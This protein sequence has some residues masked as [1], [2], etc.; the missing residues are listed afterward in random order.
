MKC[1]ISKPDV[2][3]FMNMSIEIITYWTKVL[4][5]RIDAAKRF[6]VGGFVKVKVGLLLG[7]LDGTCEV[8]FVGGTV[9]G[10]L[11][12]YNVGTLLG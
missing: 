2:L 11:E 9:I 4:L 1:Y 3:N 6:L 7:R 5:N 10:L 8:V 12:G